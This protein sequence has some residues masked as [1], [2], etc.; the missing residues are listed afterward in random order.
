MFFPC[1]FTSGSVIPYTEY[2]TSKSEGNSTIKYASAVGP[3][4]PIYSSITKG[5]SFVILPLI[6]ISQ[7]RILP[8]FTSGIANFLSCMFSCS[9]YLEYMEASSMAISLRFKTFPSPVTVLA[10]SI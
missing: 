10:K 6:L 2:V 5:L 1:F 7:S 3:L 9:G 4:S 8:G